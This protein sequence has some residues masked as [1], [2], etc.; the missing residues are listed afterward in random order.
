MRRQLPEN[1]RIGFA[2]VERRDGRAIE[3][4]V[5]VAVGAVYIP[6]LKLRR[7]RQDVVGVIGRVGLELLQHHGEQVVAGKT[8]HH[9][10][11]F[12][13]NRDRIAVVCNQRLDLRPEARRAALQQVVADRRHVDCSRSATRQQVRSLQRH[14]VEWKFAR[15]AQQHAAGAMP[16]GADQRRQAGDGARRIA[17]ATYPLHAV[18]H[19]DRRR[20]PV[21]QALAV[22]ACQRT[23]LPGRHA[24]HI[25]RAI[26]S[27]LQRP[28]TQRVPAERMALDIV[29]VQPVVGDQLVH[30]RQRQRGVGSRQQR[31]M[32]V[33]FLGGFGP[34]RVDADQLRA[35]APGLLGIAPEMQ[36]AAD[37]VAA[38]DD[39]EPRLG[40]KLDPHADLG[41]QRLRHAFAAGGGANSAVQQRRAEPVEKPPGHGF[42]LNLPHGAAIAVG[43]DG[44]RVARRNRRQA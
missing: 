20:L 37:R 19:P 34:A 2:L 38:P 1:L 3:Q 42:A 41:A 40:E 23:D 32:F 4:R 9:P 25:R 22:V 30:Q 7:R 26:R 11:R 36:V 17:A 43:N 5:G 29:M 27:P 31:D 18:I 15:G 14:L 39:D 13:R 24:A 10:G 12:R 6:V 44:L 16:P 28:L 33:A 21:D 8:P 35:A